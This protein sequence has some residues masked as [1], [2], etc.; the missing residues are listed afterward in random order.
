MLTPEEKVLSVQEQIV[1]IQN[2]YTNV[3]QCPYCDAINERGSICCPTLMRAVQA[4]LDNQDMMDRKELADRISDRA[5][6]N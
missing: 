5:Y 1:A 3:I 4:V 2:G 6:V